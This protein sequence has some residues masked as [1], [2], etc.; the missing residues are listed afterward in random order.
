MRLQKYITNIFKF[1]LKYLINLDKKE[2]FV[3]Y[4]FTLV[5]FNNQREFSRRIFPNFFGNFHHEAFT[6]FFPI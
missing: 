6:D 4:D 5:Y 2:I 1:R 3:L